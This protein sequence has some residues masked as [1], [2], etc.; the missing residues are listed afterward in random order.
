MGQK[1]EILSQFDVLRM[2]DVTIGEEG[3]SRLVRWE[4]RDRKLLDRYVKDAF[5]PSLKARSA[6]SD[7]KP[8]TDV[9]SEADAKEYIDI[10]GI[11]FMIE[12]SRTKKRPSYK[13][14]VTRFDAHICALAEHYGFDLLRAGYRT[15]EHRETGEQEPYVRLSLLSDKIKD[16]L[17]DTLEGREG[18]SQTVGVESPEELKTKVPEAI[19]IV[20][21]RNYGVLTR[22]N[23]ETYVLGR[24]LTGYNNR[25]ASQFKALVLDDTLQVLG[26]EPKHPVALVYP[27]DRANFVHQVEPRQNPQYTAIIEAF[28]KDAPEKLRTNSKIGDF[29]LLWLM[30]NG[31]ESALKGK[32]LLGDNFLAAYDMH[33]RDGEPFVRLVGAHERLE[34]HRK[35]NTKPSIEQNITMLPPL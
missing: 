32:G 5:E 34:Y 25:Q 19:K 22:L 31:A 1:V 26:K 16:D 2:P 3:F 7:D 29:A 20:A 13:D 14:V 30:F 12:T 15:L 33:V 8:P 9:A 35:A 27:F 18:I 10:D 23:G 4:G 17:V 6:Y 21:E 11:R 28:M 24:N